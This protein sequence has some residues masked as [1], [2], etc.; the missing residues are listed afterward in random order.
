MFC[1]CHDALPWGSL[2]ICAVGCNCVKFW[3]LCCV[4][5]HKLSNL[6]ESQFP[7]S[8][9]GHSTVM[10]T[11]VLASTVKWQLVGSAIDSHQNLSLCSLGPLLPSLMHLYSITLHDRKP[12]IKYLSLRLLPSPTYSLTF[13]LLK[14]TTQGRLELF[15]VDI[16][17]HL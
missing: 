9:C 1:G 17:T 4:V 11:D 15:T 12:S 2:E 3:C 13:S 6:P 14:E 16:W 8:D 10:M 7:H 5:A